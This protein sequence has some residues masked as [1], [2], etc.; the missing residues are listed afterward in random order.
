MIR[1]PNLTFAALLTELAKIIEATDKAL[2][3][4]IVLSG[5]A[6]KWLEKHRGTPAAKALGT[7]K[8]PLD[9]F[10]EAGRAFRTDLSVLVRQLRE[11][12]DQDVGATPLPLP[13]SNPPPAPG[14]RPIPR[15]T[16]PPK[17]N[18]R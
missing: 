3:P 13:P 4:A 17:R 11:I 12:Q 6:T 8:A 16:P 18:K 14:A 2:A 15:L 7:I 9:R 5:A 1:V 10:I